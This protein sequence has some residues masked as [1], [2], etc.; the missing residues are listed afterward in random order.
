M[1]T[2]VM[3]ATIF[4]IDARLVS[5]ETDLSDGGLPVFEMVGFLGSEVR[6]SKERIRTALKNSGFILPPKR[7]TVNLSPADMRKSGTS[8]DLA[9]AL[10]LISAMGVIP[11]EALKNTVIAGELSL[12]GNVLKISG[13]LSMALQARDR[14]I[15]RFILPSENAAEGSAVKGIEIIGVSSVTEAVEFL[16]GTKQIAPTEYHEDRSAPVREYDVDFADV[17][18]QTMARRA[19][20]VAVSGSHNLLL[21]GPP[22]SGKTMIARRIPTIMPPLTERES[23]ELTRMYSA[24]GLLRSADPLR[25]RPFVNAH[26]TATPQALAGGGS[27][28]G[29]GLCSLALYGT[30]FLDELPEF[31]RP[32]L[33][34]LRE[35]LED[36][37]ISIARASWKVTFPADFLLCA[38]MNP[39]KCG[40]YP[41]RTRCR[42][43]TP[44]IRR[45]LSRVSRPLL[46]RIDISCE[47]EEIGFRELSE[48]SGGGA[49][50]SEAIRARV[51][52]AFE[53]QRKR[54]SETPLRFNSE[55]SGRNIREFC[56]IGEREERLLE[57]AFREMNLSAR[58]YHRI[59]KVARTI[60]DLEHSD[61]IG[62]RHLSEA[63][64]YRSIDGR[65][66][67]GD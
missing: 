26:H 21:I 61:R 63:I 55:I 57:E 1:F 31:S 17:G 28:P 35:P 37:K 48:G 22:G 49:E 62:C 64:S 2:S 8:F 30:L 65:Y 51:A 16:N 34:V 4:G 43:T 46:D 47:S 44:E 18:G 32:A 27:V 3:S 20:E 41:D 58:G 33:E 50:S 45:Y 12:S 7:I 54:F 29:P 42:C 52:D 9:V 36:K 10:S 19:V 53:I 15:R 14:G 56:V 59:L 25:L 11:S 67:N 6:E 38:A 66:W 24:A 23:L 40:F 5:T 60:A 39:C 13:V